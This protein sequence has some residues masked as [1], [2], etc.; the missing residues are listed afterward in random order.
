MGDIV[1]VASEGESSDIPAGALTAFSATDG[2]QLWRQ[3]TPAPLFTTPVIVDNAIVVALSSE[4]A[5]LSAFD[6]QSGAPLWTIA[7]PVQG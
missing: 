1:Y 7:P 5:V 4:S 6:R 2:Q 3:L